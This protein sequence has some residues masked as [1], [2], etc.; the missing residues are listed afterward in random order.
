MAFFLSAAPDL[1]DF[2]RAIFYDR[3]LWMPE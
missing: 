3:F 1:V 2:P